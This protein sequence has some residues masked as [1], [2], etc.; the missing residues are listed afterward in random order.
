MRC[1]RAALA[2]LAMVIVQVA[3]GTSPAMAREG[4][5]PQFVGTYLWLAES[6]YQQIVSI[7]KDGTFTIVSQ[8]ASVD[9]FSVGLGTAKRTGRREVTA[10]KIDFGFDQDGKPNSITSVVYTMIFSD[11]RRGKYQSIIG[12]QVGEVFSPEESPLNTTE[13]PLATFSSTFEGQRL[14]ID[15]N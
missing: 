13:P 4:V 3:M 10:R 14:T 15:Q 2:L 9:G 1:K 12:S 8:R 7:T 11:D 5:G 6:G